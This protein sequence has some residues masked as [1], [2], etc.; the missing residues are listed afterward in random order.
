VAA[1]LVMPLVQELA[2]YYMLLTLTYLLLI[3][4]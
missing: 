4:Q 3:T 1:V 2:R